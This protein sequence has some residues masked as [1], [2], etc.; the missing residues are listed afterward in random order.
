[1]EEIPESPSEDRHKPEGSCE[2]DWVAL[3]QTIALRYEE[4]LARLAD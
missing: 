3:A 4:V 2:P 1:M